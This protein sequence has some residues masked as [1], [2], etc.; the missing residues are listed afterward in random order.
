MIEVSKGSRKDIARCLSIA[1]SLPEYFTSKA[2]QAMRRDLSGSPFFVAKDRQGKALGFASIKTITK[3]AS[4]LLRLTVA[5]ARKFHRPPSM[6]VAS[7]ASRASRPTASRSAHSSPYSSLTSPI[8]NSS[9]S[10]ATSTTS[11]GNA[12]L[13]TRLSSL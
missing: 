4:E 11:S 9:R 7:G 1:K 3:R 13:R 2:L 12:S 5:S 10:F 8:G 6:P